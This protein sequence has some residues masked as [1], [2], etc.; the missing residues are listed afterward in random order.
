MNEKD[1]KAVNGVGRAMQMIVDFVLRNWTTI[2]I[3]LIGLILGAILGAVFLQE[4]GRPL[5]DNPTETPPPAA[6]STPMPTYTALPPLPTHTDLP[7]Y[8]P[9][10][11]ATPTDT[12][13]ATDTPTN[14]PTS[15]ATPS[16]TATFTPYPTY[17]APPSQTPLPT[18]TDLP[19]YTPYPTVTP[20]DTATHTPTST[21][22]ITPLPP[23]T[24]LSNI[25]A[26]AKL[27]TM[28]ME[29]AIVE[30]TVRN[31]A[32]RACAYSA[33]HV[34][35][36]V[37]EA[38]IDLTAIDEDDIEHKRTLFDS[39]YEVSAPAPA[40]SSCRIEFFRQY[41]KQGG[42]TA[43]CFHNNWSAMSDIGRHLAMDAL[44]QDALE[45]G[46]LEQAWQQAEIALGDFARKLTGGNVDIKF[47]KA[48]N[49]PLIPDSCRLDVPNGWIQD[50]EGGWKRSG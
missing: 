9:Y 11:T 24:I 26:Q 38:G 13:T 20:T 25:R 39:F 40:I 7:T 8:T 41:E 43:V 50:Y 37:I 4:G 17:T 2:R 6:T 45:R 35:E 32:S 47:E 3:L 33:K 42:G 21:A 31:P 49:E 46:I 48:L 28:Q 18:H 16:S 44:V 15:T 19:T 10:P 1:A 34:A 12:A 30:L 27:I 23:R 14:T 5:W 36:G 22:T 29:L